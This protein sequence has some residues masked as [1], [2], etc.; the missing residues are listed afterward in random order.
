MR[1]G[2]C[3]ICGVRGPL[4]LDHN[5]TTCKARGV[6]CPSHNVRVGMYETGWQKNPEPEVVAYV[7][8]YR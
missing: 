4:V 5:H 2:G 7:D 3:E 6:L 8:R 1:E